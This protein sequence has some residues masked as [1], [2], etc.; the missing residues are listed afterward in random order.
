M[1]TVAEIGRR[2]LG[3]ARRSGEHVLRRASA[4]G[5]PLPDFLIIGAQ[6]A[7]TTSLHAYLTQHTSVVAPVT[8]EVHFFD[9]EYQ[10]GSG[11]YRANFRRL[12]PAP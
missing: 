8:K 5:R 11:W 10:R 6:K 7:G 9:H 2:Q 12:D 3:K 1:V 4:G